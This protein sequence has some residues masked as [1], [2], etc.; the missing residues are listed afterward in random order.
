VG[1]RGMRRRG[2]PARGGRA[3]RRPRPAEPVVTGHGAPHQAAPH[4]TRHF[5]LGSAPAGLS[6]SRVSS[7]VRLGRPCAETGR[8]CNCRCER[9]PRG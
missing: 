3:G 6:N 1:P 9:G 8:A 5:G 2:A 4:N 7:G